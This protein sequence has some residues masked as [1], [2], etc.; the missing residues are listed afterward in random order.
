VD[1]QAAFGER[2]RELRRRAGLSQARLAESCGEGFVAQS[3]GEIER[4]ERNCTLQTIWRLAKALK[5]EPA[6][7]FLFPA[8]RVGKSL[9]VLDTRYLDFWTAADDATK[10]KAI[11]ILSELL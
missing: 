10:R 6:E 8:G 7:L 9:S 5:C 2:V 11:R 3:V 1:I 4:G